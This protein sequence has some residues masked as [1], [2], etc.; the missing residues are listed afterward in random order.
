MATTH[1]SPSS[2]L[3]LVVLDGLGVAPPVEDNAVWLANAPL[4]HQ[5]L[6]GPAAAGEPAAPPIAG[7]PAIEPAIR[8]QLKAHGPAVGL[9]SEADMGNS[10]VGHNIMG[11][12]RIFDQGSKQ[13]EDA[14]HSGAIWGDAWNQVVGRGRAGRRV[15]F[16]G[17]LSDGNV[18]SHIRHLLAMLERAAGEGAHDLVVH[19]LFDGR[20]VS[21]YT[22]ELYL[23]QL[24]EFLTGLQLR[25]GCS[26]RVGSGGGRMGTT[27]D[28]YEA[29]WSI[30]HRGWSAHALGTA[31]GFGSATEALATLRAEN[32]GVSDQFLPEFTVVDALQQPVGAMHTGD[33]VVLFNFRGDRMI[34]FYRCLADAEFPYFDRGIRPTDLLVAGMT[35]YDGDLGIPALFLVPPIAIA[36]TI[37]EVL[38][39]AGLRQAAM[40]ETQKFGHITYFWNGNRSG[41]FDEQLEE[42]FEIPSD[43]VPFE[44]RPWMKSAETA[45]KLI[46]CIQSGSFDFIRANFAAGDMVGH[47]G[48][49]QA[50]IIAVE[51]LDLSLKRV[52]QAV[53]R[54]GGTLIITAD[55]GNCE[56]MLERD[57][58]GQFLL[59]PDGT[60]SPKKSHTLSP[61]PFIVLDFLG[62]PLQLTG[63]A[64]PGLANVGAT[65]ACLLGVPA[66]ADYEPSL[67]TAAS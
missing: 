8:L 7:A 19:P 59:R 6:D 53:Q 30:V 23:A 65:L 33:A 21:D 42:Y 58:H 56:I 17:L 41:K 63:V 2:P 62:R 31:R 3:V 32:P 52:L 67:L 14:I 1:N 43:Q 9:A 10:E 66:P 48:D 57:K 18:H 44:Q 55:H 27:M 36:D 60:R 28:R 49:L 45:D 22:A 40:A 29:D 46:E 54:C 25:Y 50:A 11:A 5:L 47:T 12:G 34:E 16:V 26:A 37:S 15:H 35:L 20:D 51:S 61:V 13:V 64:A 39:A 38:A 4:L 24:Q